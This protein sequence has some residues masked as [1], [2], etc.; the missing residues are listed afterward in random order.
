[1]SVLGCMQEKRGHP[2]T[3]K[4]TRPRSSGPAHEDS[5]QIG[6]L[7]CWLVQT[8]YTASEAVVSVLSAASLRAR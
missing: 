6:R 5:R 8:P 7:R 1:M 3:S 4:E 2:Q